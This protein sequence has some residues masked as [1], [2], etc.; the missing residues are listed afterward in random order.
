MTQGSTRDLGKS[1]ATGAVWLVLLS[2][3]IKSISIVST[4]IIARL[5]IPEDFG[6]YALS[7]SIFSFVELIRAFGFGMALIQNK[8]A[9]R[10]H[11]DTAWTL[12][13]VFSFV[14]ALALYIL[15]EP[16]SHWVNEPRTLDV[17][18][19]LTWIFI[20]D[21]FTNIGVIDFQK[22][23]LFN[24]EFVRQILI[25]LSGF[26]VTIPLVFILRSYWALLYGTLATTLVSVF[27][28]YA[29]HPFRPKFS[30][31]KSREMIHFS[32]WLQLNNVLRY[33]DKNLENFIVSRFAGAGNVGLLAM[34]KEVS[35]LPN[36]ELVESINRAAYP[37]FAKVSGE[38]TGTRNAFLSVYSSIAAVS[39]PVGGGIAI[40]A[41]WLVPLLLGDKW[42]ETVP[43]IQVLSMAYMLSA[44][45]SSASYIFLAAAMQNYNVYLTLLKL[46]FFVPIMLLLI[47]V[48]GAI[49]AA[50]SIF[51]TSRVMFPITAY[52][53]AKFI[54]LSAKDLFDSVLRPVSAMLLMVKIVLVSASHIQGVGIERESPMGLLLLVTVGVLVYILT[55][56]LLWLLQSKPEGP[57][58]N[59]LRVLQKHVVLPA[60]LSPMASSN[61]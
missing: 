20:F 43:L 49:G 14:A 27:L 33:A 26:V 46:L 37:A 15:S 17:I 34:S 55:L 42:V 44:L 31:K 50:F 24:K 23:M 58:S 3:S 29:M 45:N 47:P 10:D 60:W 36:V 4:L 28:S 52:V 40:I 54:G 59:T 5:L 53:M 57:E 13:F 8:N 61:E 48:Y 6:V 30:L 22:N 41:P 18:K 35:S 1:I 9:E 12:H 2:F 7:M 32:A 39:L 38:S 11:Y 51:L 25:K 16:I 56:T 19:F 21:A